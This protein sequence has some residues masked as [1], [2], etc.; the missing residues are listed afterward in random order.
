MSFESYDYTLVAGDDYLPVLVFIHGYCQTGQETWGETI[1]GLRAAGITNTCLIIER[2]H[3]EHAGRLTLGEQVQNL[4][5]FLHYLMQE[6]QLLDRKV[7]WV[8]HSLGALLAQEMAATWRLLTAGLITLAPVPNT[9]WRIFCNWRFW[10]HGGFISLPNVIWSVLTGHSVH[11]PRQMIRGLFT[12][13][14]CP[15]ER[16]ERFMQ[17]QRPDS[18]WIFIQCLLAYWIS[19]YTADALRRIPR[20]RKLV[21]GFRQDN[22]LSPGSIAT[23]SR[24]TKTPMVMVDSTHCWWLSGGIS[25]VVAHI[26]QTINAINR[27]E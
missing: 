16:F 20:E 10:W 19:Y 6:R 21:V 27:L 12:G 23:L 3:G 18:A 11:F 13:Y 26:C 9:G 7:I 8:G 24:H 14:N 25:A 5:D 15:Q 22:L 1:E 2:K 17:V 4:R